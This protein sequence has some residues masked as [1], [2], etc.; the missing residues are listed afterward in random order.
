[1]GIGESLKYFFRTAATVGGK[2]EGEGKERREGVS[3]CF[4]GGGSKRNF[5]I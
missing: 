4:Y 2:E 5:L 1:M 3:E